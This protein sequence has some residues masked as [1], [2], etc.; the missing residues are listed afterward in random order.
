MTR[1]KCESYTVRNEVKIECGKKKG[2]V[3]SHRKSIVW[4]IGVNDE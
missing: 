4:T 2:H 1:V 3:G